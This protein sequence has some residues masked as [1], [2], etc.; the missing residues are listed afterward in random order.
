MTKSDNTVYNSAQVQ[1]SKFLTLLAML[2]FGL[3]LSALLIVSISNFWWI[4]LIPIVI[5]NAVTVLRRDCLR[6][7]PQ[8]IVYY[9]QISKDRWHFTTRAGK[10]LVGR[11]CG[12]PFRSKIFIQMAFQT[13]PFERK[14]KLVVAF[15]AIPHEHYRYLV[16]SL[17]AQ[18]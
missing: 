2:I 18:E 9:H 1:S 12:Y 6:T 5:K 11:H 15:D 10:T 4:F 8:A 13:I 16:S 14:I 7:A 17:W 3:A